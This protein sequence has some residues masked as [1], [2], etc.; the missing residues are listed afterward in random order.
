MREETKSTLIFAGIWAS[1]VIGEKSSQ[2]NF[3]GGFKNEKS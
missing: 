1:V 2:I 3:K